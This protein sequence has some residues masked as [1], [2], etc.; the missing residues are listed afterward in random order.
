MIRCIKFEKLLD[1]GST[2]PF[3]ASCDRGESWVV[4]AHAHSH[5]STR[6][7]LK[8]IFNE[9]ISGTLA[10]IIDLP[11][12]KV[13]IVQLDTQ[14]LK[15]LKEAKFEIL[16]E[17]AVGIKYIPDLQPYRPSKD[18]LDKMAECIRQLFPKFEMQSSFYGK[19]VFDNLVKFQDYKYNTLAIQS[20]GSPIFIDG[21]MAFDGFEWELNKLRWEHILIERSPY[22]I[23]I[24]T[25]Y[26]MFDP[27]LKKI[28][29]IKDIK[30]HEI[31]HRIPNAWQIPKDYKLELKKMLLSTREKF[32][33]LFRE[34]LQ[35]KSRF[36]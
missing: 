30:I 36:L 11:W 1:N 8:P 33:P 15:Q 32:I 22:L 29:D 35:W 26:A 6:L 12:P 18:D 13:D 3:L 23:G 20:D 31:F 2:I 7:L 28:E 9:F 5:N 14:I 21:S 25:E 16:S 4:K 27:W 34:E 24:L 19:S 17:W 10:N